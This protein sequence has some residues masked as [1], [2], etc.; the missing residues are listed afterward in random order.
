MGAPSAAI[1][2]WPR[3]FARRHTR[4][5]AFS[6]SR[7]W[8]RPVGIRENAAQLPPLRVTDTRNVQV[9]AI[10]SSYARCNGLEPDSSRIFARSGKPRSRR[11]GPACAHVPAQRRFRGT[12]LVRF[13][14]PSVDCQHANNGINSRLSST[15]S[16]PVNVLAPTARN[17]R[18]YCL[19]PLHDGESTEV[20]V[21]RFVNESR[22]GYR[23]CLAGILASAPACSFPGVE[24]GVVGAPDLSSQTD[25]GGTTTP[26]Q[27]L[28]DV[29]PLEPDAGGLSV[30]MDSVSADAAV[31]SAA[32]PS[33]TL[34]P[35]G[36]CAR[37][38][39]GAECTTAAAC[40]SDAC[41]PN[42]GKMGKS[43][44]ACAAS[45]V[46]PAGS[47]SLDAQCCFPFMCRLAGPAK[48]AACQ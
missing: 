39:N 32:Y 3:G 46:G 27:D 5:G 31:D 33:V 45:C 4:G 1:V 28:L 14:N 43:M 13:R 37:A 35:D 26:D 30:D 41:G 21:P 44:G 17:R 22:K 9:D 29:G 48:P 8:P 36:G 23:L 25:V 16:A 38:A 11:F 20:A 24:L 7:A 40:C 34:E 18:T 15:P 42:P 12:V 19:H 2:N 6:R 10:G 47:C